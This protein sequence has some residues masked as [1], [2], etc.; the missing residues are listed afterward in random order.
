MRSRYCGLGP[1]GI[2]ILLLFFL[3]TGL[4][5]AGCER[6]SNRVPLTDKQRKPTLVKKSVA[7]SFL[8]FPS[9]S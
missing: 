3:G 1:F 4:K 5:G 8:G 9:H 6:K 7:L 2:L